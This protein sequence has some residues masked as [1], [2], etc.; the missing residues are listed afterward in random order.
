M[1][2]HDDTPQSLAPVDQLPDNHTLILLLA[3]LDQPIHLEI[4]NYFQ[5]IQTERFHYLVYDFYKRALLILVLDVHPPILTGTSLLRTRQ[6]T[7]EPLH[8]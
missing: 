7:N 4:L 2:L 5:Q 3:T 1:H 6:F 8:L